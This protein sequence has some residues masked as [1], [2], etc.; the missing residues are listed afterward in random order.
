MSTLTIKTVKTTLEEV[1][2]QLPI[3]KKSED[4]STFFGMVTEKCHHRIFKMDS[5]INI[6][7]SDFD[8][9]QSDLNMDDCSEEEFMEAWEAGLKS[10][11]F[12][13]VLTEKNIL[14]CPKF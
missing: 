6:N 9:K 2:M 4:G 12:M 7:T 1:Q 3:F 11:S 8:P 14:S 10:M 5:Y 13:P